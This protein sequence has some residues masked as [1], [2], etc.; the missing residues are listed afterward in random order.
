VPHDARFDA[1]PTPVVE[2]MLAT[3]RANCEPGIPMVEGDLAH[4]ALCDTDLYI[5]P[6]DQDGR[7]CNNRTYAWDAVGFAWSR[8]HNDGCP[9]DDPD[10]AFVIGFE[11]G[12][13]DRHLPVAL[14]SMTAKYLRELA[15]VRLNRFFRD[16]LPEVKPTAGYVQDGRRFLQEV[17]PVIESQRLQPAELVRNA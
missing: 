12:S 7:S 8:S 15:M 13:E 16:A 3:P 10:G 17:R 9:L 6:H 5:H 1:V 11:T 2:R 14:A 4:P